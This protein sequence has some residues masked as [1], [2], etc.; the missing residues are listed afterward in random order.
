MLISSENVVRF[1]Y[2]GSFIRMNSYPMDTAASSFNDLSAAADTP[3][4][5]RLRKKRRKAVMGLGQRYL[6][7]GAAGIAAIALCVCILA[8][9]AQPYSMLHQQ[10]VQIAQLQDRLAGDNADNQDL[11]RRIAY[12]HQPDGIATAARSLG[13]VKPGEESLAV[14]VQAP[15][16]DQSNAPAGFAEIL[17]RAWHDVVRR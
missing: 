8:K 4:R 16:S 9:I 7:I 14:T 1:I 3:A 11:E 10:Q 17:T 2:P 6:L 13:Y 15:P 5:P 12:I